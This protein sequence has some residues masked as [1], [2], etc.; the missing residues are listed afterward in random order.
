MS[1][2][3]ARLQREAAHGRRMAA[4]RP[5]DQMGGGLGVRWEAW[6]SGAVVAAAS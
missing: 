4:S 3:Q 2:P 6:M 5:A 1:G